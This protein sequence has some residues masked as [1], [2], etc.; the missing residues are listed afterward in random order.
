M[1]IAKLVL[2]SRFYATT[3]EI[4]DIIALSA[5]SA[6]IWLYSAVFGKSPRSRFIA[7]L[8]LSSRFYAITC[9]IPEIIAQ[10]FENARSRLYSAVLGE[11]SEKFGYRA[12]RFEQPLLRDNARNSRYIA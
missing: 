3:R 6:R 9:E 10:S 1:V 5:E 12:A 11:I 4:P 8:V 2:S 7:R